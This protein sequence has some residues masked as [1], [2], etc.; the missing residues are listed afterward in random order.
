MVICDLHRFLESGVTAKTKKSLEAFLV[1]G[2]GCI[3][4][5]VEAACQKSDPEATFCTFHPFDM[6]T[7]ADVDLILFLVKTSFDPS[8]SPFTD[9]PVCPVAFDLQS[10]VPSVVA[11]MGVR[12]LTSFLDALPAAWKEI[13]MKKP[14]AEVLLFV[15]ESVVRLLCHEPDD[16]CPPSPPH[17]IVSIPTCRTACTYNLTRPARKLGFGR[18]TAMS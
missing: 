5:I 11:K 18:V 15:S 16:E 13:E 4:Y 17:V 6:W 8:S 1:F 12:G 2:F 10:R 14:A 3:L 7:W 9:G